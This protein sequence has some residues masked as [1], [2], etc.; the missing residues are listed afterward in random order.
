MAIHVSRREWVYISFN[1]FDIRILPQTLASA[2]PIPSP[3]FRLR[4][5]RLAC[6]SIYK[7]PWLP[8]LSENFVSILREQ[9]NIIACVSPLTFTDIIHLPFVAASHVNNNSSLLGLSLLFLSQLLGGFFTQQQL[10]YTPPNCREI[11][12]LR[13]RERERRKKQCA[14]TKQNDLHSIEGN[15]FFYFL[16]LIVYIP[17][18]SF[19][20][21]SGVIKPFLALLSAAASSNFRLTSALFLSTSACLVALACCWK[22]NNHMF[23]DFF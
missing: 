9:K 16:L 18:L 13:Q 23:F 4:N 12:P 2:L 5:R 17:T 10:Q 21:L 19:F 11:E 3:I 7:S 15:L 22:A 20:F 14:T 6:S 1:N 8:L